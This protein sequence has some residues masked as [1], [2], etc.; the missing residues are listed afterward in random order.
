MLKAIVLPIGMSAFL[1]HTFFLQIYEGVSL[2]S[3]LLV[4]LLH[5]M[6]ERALSPR[7]AW[8]LRASI[9]RY[10]RYRQVSRVVYPLMWQDHTYQYYPLT[11][12]R[13]IRLLVLYPGS[14]EEPLRGDIVEADLERWPTY[15]AL[16][17]TWADESGDTERSETVHCVKDDSKLSITRNCDAALRR[18]RLPNQERRLWVDAVCIN[19]NSDTERSYQVALMTDIYTNARH[20]IAFTGEST[21]RTDLLYDWLNGIDVADLDIPSIGMFKDVDVAEDSILHRPAQVWNGPGAAKDL[22]NEIA[23]RFERHWRIDWERL[24]TTFQRRGV[25]EEKPVI[26]EAELSQLVTEYFSRRWFKRV[27]VLQEVSLPALS[28]TRVICGSKITTAERAMHLVSLLKTQGTG[29]TTQ[30]F[31]LLRQRISG[32]RISHLLDILIE[33]RH[34]E[35]SDP[36]DKI[37]GVLSIARSMDEERFPQLKANYEDPT[38]T[39]YWKFSAFFIQHHGPGF[40]LSLIKS[41]PRLEGL[42]SWAGD[43]TAPWPNYNAVRGIDFACRSRMANY[44]DG[45][46][47][48]NM[49][50]GM[51]ILSLLRPRILRGYVTKDGHIDDSKGMRIEA[52]EML[53][54]DEVM[55]EMYPGLAALLK[56]DGEYYVFVQVCPYALSEAGVDQLVRKW[57]RVVVYMEGVE[58]SEGSK[59][60]DYLGAREIFKI[61]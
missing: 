52:V 17:Y 37:F 32:P 36:R 46:G 28:K 7:V 33:T 1:W 19:Q 18:L 56:M 51:P 12:M 16:S 14:L 23:V 27:W 57:S 47:D 22:A 11:R 29:S 3:L 61:R 25:V 31:M 15:D 21:A 43:W 24:S 60:Q 54:E 48:V 41:A 34:R 6:M 40:F 42:P 30:V 50:N 9:S 49:E 53:Q 38:P 2:T 44:Q 39:V 5:K 4:G 13:G 55:I 20:V 8:L 35:C 26:P 59:T 58:R 45:A 10:A